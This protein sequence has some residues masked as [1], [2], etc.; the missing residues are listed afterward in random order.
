MT[1]NNPT[2][3]RDGVIGQGGSEV[4]TVHQ[5]TGAEFARYPVAGE[6]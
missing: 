3:T 4:V 6:G 1:N 5:A 2:I